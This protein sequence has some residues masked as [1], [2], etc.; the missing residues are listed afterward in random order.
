MIRFNAEKLKVKDPIDGVLFS[1]FYNGIS[2]K[3]PVVRKIEWR[4]LGN[5]HELLDKVEKF[6]NVEETLKAMKSAHK[7]PKKFEEKKNKD[8]S[9]LNDSKPFKKKFCD[10]NFTPLNTN[11]SKVLMEIKT[12]LEYRKPPKNFGCSIEPEF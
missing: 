7:L 2:P 8:H 11:I 1:T 6:T 3:E 5:L 12:D 4:Q 9:R 10:L